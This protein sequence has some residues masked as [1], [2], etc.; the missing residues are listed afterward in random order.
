LGVGQTNKTKHTLYCSCNLE[1]TDQFG[2]GF[3]ILN[4]IKKNI[5]SFEPHNEILCKLRIKGRFN[6]LSIKGAHA[7]TE[8][9]T[10]EEKQNSMKIYK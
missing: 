9:K 5:L 7:L 3:M 1:K 6:N 8:E 2:T 10:D 4:E